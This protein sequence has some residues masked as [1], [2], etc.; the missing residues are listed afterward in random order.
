MLYRMLCDA[1]GS[2][3]DERGVA[4]PVKW[5]RKGKTY[6]LGAELAKSFFEMGAIE[7]ADAEPV[8]PKKTKAKKGAP[9]N[10]GE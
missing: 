1:R 6:P 2:D 9:E 3:R 5:Y 10:K 7:E 8:E 4:L